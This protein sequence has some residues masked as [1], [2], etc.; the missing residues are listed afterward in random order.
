MTFCFSFRTF[1]EPRRCRVIE[2]IHR[3]RASGM[4]VVRR[5]FFRSA[6]LVLFLWLLVF[7]SLLNNSPNERSSV[8]VKGDGFGTLFPLYLKWNGRLSHNDR[9]P[10]RARGRKF[11]FT[12]ISIYPNSQAS[13]QLSRLLESGDVCPNPGPTTAAHNPARCSECKK[14]VTVAKTH[15]AI[16]CDSCQK[17]CLIKCGGV[18]PQDY[19]RFQLEKEISGI[20]PICTMPTD[21]QPC[22][23]RVDVPTRD[24]EVFTDLG[25]ITNTHG[26]KIAHININGLF[27]KMSEIKF[28]LQEI[29][30]DILGLTESHLNNDTDNG[31]YIC[32]R[33]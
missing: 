10:G 1:V 7:S 31:R 23:G 26:L 22:V 25:Q 21:L 4:M 29:R 18:T 19:R 17:W 2:R 14:T 30:F 15:R 11:F 12:R 32:R 28:L 3:M 27:N 6:I 33:I 5:V 24:S 20:C 13:F 9:A 16:N 8:F